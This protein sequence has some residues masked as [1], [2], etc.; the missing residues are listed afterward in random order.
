MSSVDTI[1]GPLDLLRAF[2]ERDITHPTWNEVRILVPNPDSA[3]IEFSTRRFTY[4]V[5]ADVDGGNGYLGCTCTRN[6]A[7][8]GRDL[9]DGPFTESTC[10]EILTEVVDQERNRPSRSKENPGSAGQNSHF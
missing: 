8:P 3:S 5:H 6:G 4:S 2:F 10:R 1:K 7:R 9:P